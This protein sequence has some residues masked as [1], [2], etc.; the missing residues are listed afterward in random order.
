[1]IIDFYELEYFLGKCN[2]LL[3]MFI[4]LDRFGLVRGTHHVF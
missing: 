4:K 3:F 2:A 1:M